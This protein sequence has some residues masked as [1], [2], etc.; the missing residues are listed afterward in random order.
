VAI[1]TEHVFHDDMMVR[2]S[3]AIVAAAVGAI[4][5]LLVLLQLKPYEQMRLRNVSPAIQPVD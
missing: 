1:L 3:M 2:T 4:A 5:P